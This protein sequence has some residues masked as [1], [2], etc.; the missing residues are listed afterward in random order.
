MMVMG[1]E[2][3]NRESMLM[4]SA[5]DSRAVK[6]WPT[7]NTHRRQSGDLCSFTNAKVDKQCKMM[8]F[9]Y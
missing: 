7:V 8:V 5:G 1:T 3:V 6:W 2:P 4:C 9:T